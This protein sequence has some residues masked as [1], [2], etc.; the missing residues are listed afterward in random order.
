MKG[1]YYINYSTW[2]KGYF[3]MTDKHTK[4]LVKV[5]VKPGTKKPTIKAGINIDSVY[6]DENG[7]FYYGYIPKGKVSLNREWTDKE[8][9]INNINNRVAKK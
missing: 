2:D 4:K 3:T 7:N 5:R 1:E 9:G 8:R 6:E